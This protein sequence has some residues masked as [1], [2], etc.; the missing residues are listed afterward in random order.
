MSKFETTVLTAAAVAEFLN[1]GRAI[2]VCKPVNAKGVRFF[3]PGNNVLKE[4][5]LAKRFLKQKVVAAKAA[6]KKAA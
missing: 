2:T 6:A 4:K 3:T 1:K 5:R